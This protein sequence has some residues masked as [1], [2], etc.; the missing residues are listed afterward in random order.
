MPFDRASDGGGRQMR[1]LSSVFE[2]D[3]W[4]PA[5]ASGPRIYASRARVRLQFAFDGSPV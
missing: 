1:K 4:E 5:L 2:G 3:A